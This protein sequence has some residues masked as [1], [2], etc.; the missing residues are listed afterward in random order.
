MGTN[1][2][3]IESNV[4]NIN[5][6]ENETIITGSKMKLKLKLKQNLVLNK[7][8]WVELDNSKTTNNEHTILA[9]CFGLN[10]LHDFDSGCDL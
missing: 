5:K 9:T 4:N 7:D 3:Q 2:I 10:Y 8:Q 6:N 1:D